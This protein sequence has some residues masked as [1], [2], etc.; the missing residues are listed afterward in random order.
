MIIKKTESKKESQRFLQ[1]QC[2]QAVHIIC[3]PDKKTDNPESTLVQGED[4]IHIHPYTLHTYLGGFKILHTGYREYSVKSEVQSQTDRQTD[5]QR[6]STS[7][8]WPH[9]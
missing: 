6:Q 7:L 3:Q 2:R 8:A 5:R 9:P 1:L 4:D